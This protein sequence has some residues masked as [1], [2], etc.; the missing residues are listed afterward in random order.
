MAQN[1]SCG[2][3]V[4]GSCPHNDLGLTARELEAK[5]RTLRQS[6]YQ[7]RARTV[8]GPELRGSFARLFSEPRTQT[9]PRDTLDL[10]DNDART[11]N[12][13]RGTFD[14]NDL[15]AKWASC[16][17]HPRT[18]PGCQGEPDANWTP[19]LQ[20]EGFPMLRKQR[21]KAVAAHKR[22]GLQSGPAIS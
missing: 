20:A 19:S 10:N 11:S 18:K 12:F 21:A 1:W 15:A 22:S 2:A 13:I 8:D 6:A 14:L 7:R 9:N 16:A 3:G 17:R 4:P 5:I